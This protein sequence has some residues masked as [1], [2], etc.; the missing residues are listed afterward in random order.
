[1]D[2]NSTGILMRYVAAIFPHRT[3][4]CID[5]LLVIIL[6]TKFMTR[7]MESQTLFDE[8]WRLSVCYSI[9]CIPPIWRL[10]CIQS[11]RR[12]CHEL[13]RSV[14]R[15]FF[16][17]NPEKTRKL[18]F[19][20]IW[21]VSCPTRHSFV[22]PLHEWRGMVSCSFDTTIHEETSPVTCEITLRVSQVHSFA[23]DWNIWYIWTSSQ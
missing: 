13:I 1:M 8:W 23:Q 12:W 20:R 22:L 9:V 15:R 3:H 5:D 2:R 10:C 18:H 11:S 21:G 14:V 4:G 7:H 17:R 19:I 6:R 16:G